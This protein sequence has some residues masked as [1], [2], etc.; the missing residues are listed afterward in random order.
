MLPEDEEEIF[1]Y[2]SSGICRGV[3][4]A[5]ARRIVDRFGLE[6]LDILEAEPERLNLIKGITAKKAQEIAGT[7]PPAHGPPA[8]DGVS[9][10]VPELPPVLAMQLRQQY[11]DAALEMVRRNPY[12]LSGRRVRR[13]LLR[14]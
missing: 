5:T 4:P 13:G 10:P 12:L 6:T 7:V 14:H 1:S 8:A 3:G 2:L 11:G 9:R